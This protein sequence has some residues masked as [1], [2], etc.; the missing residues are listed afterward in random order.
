M[1]K[2]SKKVLTLSLSLIIGTPVLIVLGIAAYFVLP[3]LVIFRYYDKVE[4][5]YYND[6]ENTGYLSTM[7]E[8][9]IY[10][11]SN[12]DKGVNG[13]YRMDL[14]D[15]NSKLLIECPDVRRITVNE[16]G[17]Y[18]VGLY[19]TYN[20]TKYIQDFFYGLFKSDDFST[21][22][23]IMPQ[24]L[25]VYDFFLFGD[26]FLSVSEKYQSRWD[27]MGSSYLLK[28][29]EMVESNEN[30]VE[31]N[32]VYRESGN[33]SLLAIRKIND[34]PI[35]FL[36]TYTF[37]DKGQVDG[38]RFYGTYTFAIDDKGDL[39][40][41]DMIS[42]T[43]R[44]KYGSIRYLTNTHEIVYPYS[45]ALYFIS[46]DNC[47]ITRQI[48][49]G[50]DNPQWEGYRINHEILG[51]DE[52]D[53]YLKTVIDDCGR[54]KVIMYLVVS[55]ND[56]KCDKI[57]SLAN[58]RKSTIY[59]DRENVILK[60]NNK[61]YKYNIRPEGL[62]NP[63]FLVKM[64]ED[65]LVVFKAGDWLFLYSGDFYDLAR[66]LLCRIN[67]ETDEVIV[68]TVPFDRSQHD[69]IHVNKDAPR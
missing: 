13:I 55:V 68:N 10:Y 24:Y 34:I 54:L 18:Y 63:Q 44:Y 31:V 6:N 33:S 5:Q 45:R 59:I 64:K 17:L 23:R 60:E 42:E 21:A 50:L 29:G 37:P 58:D 25:S 49:L 38:E 53:I 30:E 12:E 15:G 1:K 8:D 51:F 61:I 32:K 27:A 35:Y 67:V 26:G 19:K 57:L 2:K 65:D 66:R 11:F 62:T 48:E 22:E 4:L 69:E 43:F 36:A 14:D 28:S 56:G 40:D 3:N 9:S 16:D 52:S 41:Y 20:E 47:E 46:P 39:T 7:Y